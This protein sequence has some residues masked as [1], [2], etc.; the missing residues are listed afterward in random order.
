MQQD[1]N[2]IFGEQVSIE[3]GDQKRIR[4][5]LEPRDTRSSASDAADR[6]QKPSD[7]RAQTPKTITN[8]IGMKLALIPAGEFLMGS[9]GQRSGC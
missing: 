8:S 4:V 3:A 7:P 9:P 6:P 2:K 5:R 1:G